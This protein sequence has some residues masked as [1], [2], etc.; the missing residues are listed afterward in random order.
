MKPYKIEYF[1]KEPFCVIYTSIAENR[2]GEIIEELSNQFLSY[3]KYKLNQDK[4]YTPLEKKE[5]TKKE[6]ICISF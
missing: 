2:K 6:N 5:D 3:K 1:G 4:D